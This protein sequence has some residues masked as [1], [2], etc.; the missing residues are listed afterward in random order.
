MKQ[1]SFFD[2]GELDVRW[3][4]DPALLHAVLAGDREA[5]A[6]LMRRHDPR[7]RRAL[8]PAR[9]AEF[10]LSLLRDDKRTLRG[11]IARLQKE[12]A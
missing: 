10:W 8:P 6:E 11:W 9:A 12:V 4:D 7:V 2:S 3:L 5:F 1:M